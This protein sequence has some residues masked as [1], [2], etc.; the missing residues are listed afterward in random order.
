MRIIEQGVTGLA[1][2]AWKSA[3]DIVGVRAYQRTRSVDATYNSKYDRDPDLF[4]ERLTAGHHGFLQV[5]A[6][7]SLRV[8]ERSYKFRNPKTGI[9]GTEMAIM[10]PVGFVFDISLGIAMPIVISSGDPVAAALW[11]VGY[12]SL[13]NGVSDGINYIK[14]RAIRVNGI[15]STLI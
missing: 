13:A 7:L 11:K 3:K 2:Y 8:L 9:S 15:P 10:L 1:E 6:P 5:L 12:N 4:M 14:D